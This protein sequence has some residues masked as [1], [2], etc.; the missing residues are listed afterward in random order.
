MSELSE[1]S[2]AEYLAK[3]TAAQDRIHQDYLA[4]QDYEAAV[5]ERDA[6]EQ[7]LQQAQDLKQTHLNHIALQVSSMHPKQLDRVVRILDTDPRNQLSIGVPSM[8]ARKYRR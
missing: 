3:C 4:K 2:E 5:Q 8:F 7:Q 6:V 1:M